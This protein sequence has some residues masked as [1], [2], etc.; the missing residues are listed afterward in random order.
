MV[1]LGQLAPPSCP[2]TSC[3][4]RG[5]LPAHTWGREWA[6]SCA[7]NLK[8][9][10]N[11]CWGGAFP[12]SKQDYLIQ[13]GLLLLGVRHWG[14]LHFTHFLHLL[15]HVD[16]L[17]QLLYLRFQELDS[18]LFVMLPCHCSC[19]GGM[20]RGDP[21]LELRLA[22]GLKRREEGKRSQDPLC[23]WLEINKRNSEEFPFPLI[24]RMKALNPL[25]REVI[26][27][28]HSWTGR[29]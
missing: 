15:I 19:T 5:A 25:T 10:L 16:L 1:W 14:Q 2:H 26:K 17:L 21:V 13:Y 23:K 4:L 24:L 28:L 8:K 6:D 29:A 11:I 18:V 12:I 7:A 20:D 22:R 27:D 9:A 3:L